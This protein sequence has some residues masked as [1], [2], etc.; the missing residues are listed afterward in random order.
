MKHFANW[1]EVRRQFRLSTDYI[2]L[3]T[4]QFMSSHPKMVRKAIRKFR[5]KLD[6]NP[7]TCIEEYG[8]KMQE[9]IQKVIAA[10]MGAE[11]ED[12]ALTQGAT[13]GLGLLYNGLDIREGEEILTTKHDH[14][15]HREAVHLAT[16]RK[17]ATVREI[18]MYDDVFSATKEEIV[19]SVI[20]EI[21]D[22][23]RIVSVTWV[24]SGTGLK[25]PVGEIGK[26]ILRLNEERGDDRRILFCV[27][28][29][30]GFG[31]ETETM[32]DLQCDFFITSCHKWLYGPRGTGFICA[33]KDMWRFALPVIPDFSEVMKSEITEEK[34]RPEAM[35]GKQAT[36]GGFIDYEH[37]WALPE[38]FRFHEK[39]GRQRIAD[40]VHDLNSY[41]KEKLLDIEHVELLTPLSPELSAG[42][43][44]FNVKGFSAD[45]AKEH[46]RG[47]RIISTV[48]PYIPP[49]V[50]FTPGIYNT[51]SEIDAA[52]DVV[53]EMR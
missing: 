44:A 9:R 10:Y 39:I 27:D 26:E 11:P 33:A 35:S 46:L 3:G 24:H 43:I 4:S 37:R 30:H 50:R 51:R 29:V 12:I 7:V 20:R 2:H 45:E 36:P 48:A 6:E 22:N 49:A 17:N 41:C 19:H 47:H 14:Y 13:S 21:R 15:C 8:D 40:H 25:I 28:G 23:T 42:I 53:R 38:A 5:R 32:E 16:E 34:S 1:E 18:C 52:I 31:I